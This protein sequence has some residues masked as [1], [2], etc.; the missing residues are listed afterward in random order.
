[1]SLLGWGSLALGAYTAYEGSKASD[2]QAEAM[3]SATNVSQSQLDFS[4]SQYNRALDIYGDAEENLATYYKSLTPEKYKTMGLDAYDEQFKMAE[5]TYQQNLAQ[6]GLAGSG[7]EAE[8]MMGMQM[9]GAKD[10]AQISV[11]ADQQWAQEQLGFVGMGM[12]QSNI[13]QQNIASSSTNMANTL[14]NQASVYG[15]QA[16]A[17]GQGVGSLVSGA[18][19]AN[20]YNPGTV[21]LWGN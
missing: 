18:M 14:S 10:R 13:A 11:Q 3:S 17:A 1:M 9:Q 21:S 2:A 16:S 5:N 19:Y 12:G 7:V 4:K 8:G 20:A 15:Q 6:R